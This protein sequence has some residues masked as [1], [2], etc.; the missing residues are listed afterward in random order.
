MGDECS[1]CDG[2][3]RIA[4]SEDG[5]PWSAW[6]ELPPGSDLA[7]QMGIVQPVDCPECGG[8]GKEAADD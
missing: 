4:N 6:A 8:S 5:E 7:V 1:R 3:G 2:E